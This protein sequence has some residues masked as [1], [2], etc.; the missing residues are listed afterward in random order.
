MSRE[1]DVAAHL[2][3]GGTPEPFLPAVLESLV[4]VV[5]VLLVN[6][7]SGNP[8]G[9]NARTLE[10]SFFGRTG[11]LVVDRAPFTNFATA[12]NRVIDLH[13]R[14]SS[15]PWAAM[16]DADDVH[17]PLAGTI[18]RNLRSL[19]PEIARVDGYQRHLVQ[20]FRWFSEV[21]RHC[22]FFR[23][24]PE[25]RFE[26]GVHEQLV[27]LSGRTVAVPYTYEH[28]GLVIPLRAIAAKGRL[29][30]SLG[31]AGETIADA[32]VER[33]DRDRYFRKEYALAMRFDAAHAPAIE[34]RRAAYEEHDGETFTATE[35]AVARA[36]PFPRRIANAV[37]RMNYAYRVY[38]R[39]LDPTARALVRR[40]ERS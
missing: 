36:Q 8:D 12:R 13:R 25:V 11:R 33:V 26:S 34:M 6:D 16:V 3:V 27:G 14:A 39:M 22:C 17:R 1:P 5:R 18:A 7:N 15:A 21:G 31:Q 30:S 35:A 9:P 4:G 23:M 20:S 29:Y 24:G 28:Y 38:G 2:I 19:P 10:D 40:S 32:D 37:R